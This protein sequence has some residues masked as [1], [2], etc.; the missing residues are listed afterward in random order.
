FRP[1]FLNRLD[2]IVEFKNLDK[3][4]LIKVVD[5]FIS[6]LASQLHPKRIDL[7]VTE[8]AV[9]WL[10]E[11]GHEP[12][13]GARPFSRTVDEYLKKPLVDDILFGTLMKGGKVRVDSHGKKGLEFQITSLE[14]LKKPKVIKGRETKALTGKT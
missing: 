1:E 13:Y 12:A 6:E 11:K 7:E 10:F 8:A 3:P 9:D 5:K 4:I 14:D 2:A